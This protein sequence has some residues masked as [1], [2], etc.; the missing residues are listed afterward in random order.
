MLNTDECIIED[1]E[2]DAVASVRGT[3]ISP[4]AVYPDYA[5]GSVQVLLLDPDGRPAGFNAIAGSVD[6]DGDFSIGDLNP[7]V[8]LVLGNWRI[9][10]S[11]HP[12][13]PARVYPWA[14]A[15]LR[16]GPVT[17]C[18]LYVPVSSVSGTITAADTKLPL[19]KVSVTV[20]LLDS[21]LFGDAKRKAWWEWT[22][23]TNS[24]GLFNIGGLGP[25]THRITHSAMAASAQPIY[26]QY[27]V[28]SEN[29]DLSLVVPAA[30]AG[31]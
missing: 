24:N 23:R 15:D 4:P 21:P 25:G 3:L 18:D 8:Y 7:G 28:G 5:G 1:F 27:G 26:L 11:D 2:L 19:P 16:R 10:S 13:V 22:V 20:A 6:A 30:G 12:L 17:R 9:L 29:K 31:N 14:V